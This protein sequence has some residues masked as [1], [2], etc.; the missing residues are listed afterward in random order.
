M[1]EGCVEEVVLV[2]SHDQVIGQMEK[3]QAHQ[4][5]RLHRAVSVCLFDASGRWLLQRRALIKYHSSLLYANSCCSHPRI[6]EMAEAAAHRRVF[7]ELG[8]TCPLVPL[9]SFVYK[10][11]V[12][13]GLIEHEFDHL[14]IGNFDG[15]CVL[16]RDEVESVVWWGREEIAQALKKTP[17]IFARWFPFVFEQVTAKVKSSSHMTMKAADPFLYEH[18]HRSSLESLRENVCSSSPEKLPPKEEK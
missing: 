1:L 12:G 11:D 5:G 7:E 6:H 13:D 10:V 15:T 18:D 4:E 3:L 2:D 8:V 14:F 9:T 17:S 16:N